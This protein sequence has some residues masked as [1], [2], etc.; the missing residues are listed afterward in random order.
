MAT[1]NGTNGSNIIVG[2]NAGDVINAGGGNDIVLGGNG[3]DTLNGGDGTDLISGGNGNDTL[4]GGAGSD[5]VLGGA[6]NDTLIRRVAD[7]AAYD[8]YD[9]GNGTDTLRLVVSDAVFHSAAFQSD[10]AQLQAKLAQGSATDYLDSI[11]L[12]VT[13]IERLEVIVEGNANHAPT[14]IALTANTVAENAAGA[15]IGTLSTVDPDA[16]NTHTYAVSDSRFEVVGNSL[17]LRA[18]ESLNFENGSQVIVSITTKDGGNLSFT[19]AFTINVTN[20]NE[21]PTDIALTGNTVAENTSVATTIGTLSTVDPDAGN[22]HTYTVSDQR[23][24]VVGNTLKLKAGQ[25][26]DF[27]T[28]P[29]IN[30]N[31]TSTDAGGL[32]VVKSFIVNVTNV[33]EV[34][35]AGNDTRAAVEDVPLTIS[36]ASL[37]ANDSDPDGNPL[38]IAGFGNAQNGTVTFDGT[39]FTFV[40]A[41]DF[42]GVA[43]FQYTA[44]D[45]NG[46]QST[47]T[48]TVNVAADADDLAIT[49]TPAAGAADD[50]FIALD[51]EVVLNDLDG[52]ETI[53]SIEI[54]GV[55]DSYVLSAGAPMGDGGW[56]LAPAELAGLKLIPVDPTG[57]A[58]GVFELQIIATSVDGSDTNITSASLAVSIA[59]PE[60]AVS[61]RVIEGYIAGATVFADTDNDGFLDREDINQNGILDAGEDAD[62]DGILGQEAFATTAADGTFTLI[63]GSGPL[64]TKGGRDVSTGLDFLGVLKAPEGSTVVTPLTTL[65]AELSATL[66][67]AGAEAAVAA[68]FGLDENIDLKSFDP[69]P[70]AL[71]GNPEATAVLSASVQVYSTIAQ[72][73]AAGGSAE[74]A[75]AAIAGVIGETSGVVNLG[76]AAVIGTIVAD[77][78]FSEAAGAAVASVVAA[79][80]VS[81]Q[82][83]TDA[84]EIAQAAVVAQ[85]ETAEALANTNFG[86]PAEVQ[87]LTDTYADPVILSDKVENAEVGDVDGA[88]VGTIG[89]DTLTG[90][91]GGVPANDTIDGLDGNDTIS[92]LAGN[93]VLYGGAGIDRLIGGGGD[94]LLDGGTGRDRAEFADATGGIAVNLALGTVTGLGVGSDTLRSI[95]HVGG[96]DF[97]D[98]FV[99]TGFSGTSANAGSNGAINLFEG[100]GGDDLI[101]GNGNTQVSYR[102]ATA[103][104]TVNIAMGQASG[105]A[106]VGTD[107]FSGV[108]SVTG[109]DFGDDLTGGNAGDQFNGGAGD[110]NITGGGGVDSARYFAFVNDTVTGGVTINM[111][112]GTVTGDASVGSDTLLSI[113]NIR[114][115]SFADSYT[116]TGFSGSSA[117]AGSN[118]TFNEFEGMG[119]NDS[120]VGNGNTRLLFA[121]ATAGVTVD[122]AAGTASGNASV[123]NDTISTTVVAGFVGGVNGVT[124]SQFGDTLLGSG[125]A[126]QT[127]VVFDGRGGDD[128]IDGRGGFDQA[129]YNSDAAVAAGISVAVSGA[130]LNWTV[131]GD[132]AVGTDTLISVEFDPRHQLCRHVRRHGLQRREHRHD[133]QR[134]GLQRVRRHGR[135]RHH[136]RQRQYPAQLRQCR[137]LR[138][139]RSRRRHRDRQLVG[140]HRHHHRRRGARTRLRRQRLHL[141]RCQQQQPGG[142]EWQ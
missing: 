26:L 34:P 101:T 51:I 86:N 139:G 54:Q 70:G 91:F 7:G 47:A 97:V 16:G 13:S 69:V 46:A 105:D 42:A 39:N 89:N 30:V 19:E 52:S 33:N 129:V 111:A 78:D 6:G 23:F 37:L 66:G 64:V 141:G 68:A 88:L 115:S 74:D 40:P 67:I 57:G 18:G 95:E 126:N 44:Q 128:T 98:T 35:V 100:R 49:P 8:L 130:G 135:Q 106:S 12:Q 11:N 1:I 117:N 41:D 122:I 21:A 38:T 85:G 25:S 53:Q 108:N 81:I 45:A 96:S 56:R 92:G 110:D 17:K 80:N 36:A 87:S 5:I 9:G 32:P 127:T 124:G 77:L 83:A 72:I 50:A 10:L 84:T 103:A 75:V 118:G 20:V 113:E 4:N 107:S 121:Q 24:E 15:V 48:V 94:D 43:S 142:P 22:T 120:V 59:P 28:E 104:V 55:P 132:N 119:G 31:V 58:S 73:E 93:D 99:A 63:G 60:N 131:T 14:D 123:G 112:A 79:A 2:T 71:A 125:N 61:G 82:S 133:R 109:S 65:V 116:A 137:W 138:D 62:G 29:S 27:E 90:D 140:R 134:L 76:D 136:H 3:N 114:G 102:N